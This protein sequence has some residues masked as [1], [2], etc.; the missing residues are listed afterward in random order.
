MSDV[1][2]ASDTNA[3]DALLRGCDNVF[4]ADELKERLAGG[5]RLRVK[6]GM[7]PTAPD[8]TLG[9]TVVLRKLRQFQDLGHKAVLIIG[10]YTAMIGD[11]TGRSK[12]RPV[13]TQEQIEVN[14]RTYLNQAG[15]VLDLSEDKLEVRHNSEWLTKMTFAD[16]LALM[17]QMTVARMLERDT[18]AKRQAQNKE[19]YLHELLYPLMQARDSVAIEADVELG[20]TDQTF[21]NLCGRDLQRAAGQPPQIVMV[22]PLLV[23]TDGKEKMSKSMGNYIAITDPP[24][25][26]FG[27]VMRVPD[28]LLASYFEL[29]TDV[30]TAE[31][32]SLTDASKCNPRDS[33]ERLAKNIITQYHD[34][35]A[36]QTAAEEFK[37]VHGGRGGGGLP[38]DIPEFA[39]PAGAADGGTI[40]PIDLL[41]LCK[42]ETSRSEA[43]RIVA[44]RGIRLNGEVVE[45]ALAPLAITDGDILQRG[46][47]RFLR[48]RLS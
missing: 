40:V 9:H 6:L 18:F 10:D 44:E 11:P 28:E 39:I 7:D 48:L 19:I 25:E 29:V 22:M 37:R 31:I 26:M 33:K 1:T 15:H 12:A 4:T 21:N 30:P 41:T 5:K 38:D 23:G 27:K 46:K 34:A 35:E 2:Q 36:A 16:V 17:S 45:D 43:R 3:F 20:G 8:L 14:A 42:F 13:L 47:R 32:A 24:S